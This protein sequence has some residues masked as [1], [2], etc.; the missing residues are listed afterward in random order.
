M[1]QG[2]LHSD[3]HASRDG[4]GAERRGVFRRDLR[5]HLRE[6]HLQGRNDRGLRSRGGRALHRPRVFER[7]RR[8]RRLRPAGASAV[9]AQVP[10]VRLL[11]RQLL[12]RRVHTTRV[13]PPRARRPRLTAADLDCDDASGHRRLPSDGVRRRWLPIGDGRFRRYDE[14]ERWL[15]IRVGHRGLRSDPPS[16]PPPPTNPLLTGDL[17]ATEMAGDQTIISVVAPIV[18]AL[19]LNFLFVIGVLL[20]HK[21]KRAVGFA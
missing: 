12:L 14:R 18:G 15:R 3:V 2:A 5:R 10:S 20:L 19:C 9:Q 7:R 13:R 16:P 21:R 8:R 17:S 4:G 11:R 1:R 6:R